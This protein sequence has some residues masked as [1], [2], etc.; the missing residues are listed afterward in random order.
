VRERVEEYG[1]RE[2]EYVNTIMSC[3]Y[4]CINYA[5]VVFLFAAMAHFVYCWQYVISIMSCTYMCIN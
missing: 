3:I 5:A 2:R 4:M 1:V